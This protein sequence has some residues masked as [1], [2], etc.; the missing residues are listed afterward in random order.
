MKRFLWIGVTTVLASGAWAGTIQITSPRTGDFLGRT[1]QLKF[2]TTNSFAQARVAATITNVA[3]PLIRFTK[4]G[5]FDPNDEN[6][7]T[8]NLDLNFDRSTPEGL[9]TIVVTVTE[10]G[11]SYPVTTI[12]NVTIDVVEPKFLDSNPLSGTFVRG[13]VPIQLSLQENNIE[14]WRV[15]V[16]G[17][18]IPNN[19][20]NTS[21]VN[22]TW[23]TAAIERDG[24]QSINIKVDDKAKNSA[25]KGIN[26]TL[27]RVAPSIQILSPTSTA[28]RPGATIPVAVDIL[29]QFSGSVTPL[30]VDVSMYTTGN[31]LIGR[32][33][34]ISARNSGNN[35]NWTGRI[36]NTR[37]LPRQFYLRVTAIDRAGN[38]ATTQQVTVNL[39]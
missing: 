10:P 31:V 13:L 35:L 3:N 15:Q 29:D 16:N 26:V 22:V 23:D 24:S 27:D 1:N 39:R 14:E 5:D 18:D 30:A 38:P 25:N 6:K 7:I 20:G 34:R 36:R 17:T 9:Y 28:F 21:T 37:V 19:T 4:Q 8:G 2:T 33:A 11:N 12:S 32:V